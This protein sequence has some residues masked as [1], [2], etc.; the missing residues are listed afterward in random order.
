[1]QSQA[2]VETGLI[3][4]GFRMCKLQ[5]PLYQMHFSHDALF[6][7]PRLCLPLL[8][9]S[10]DLEALDDRGVGGL[11][12]FESAYRLDQ[13]DTS[14]N[15]LFMGLIPICFVCDSLGYPRV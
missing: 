7:L 10:H 6:L 2:A 4:E 3:S 8:Q 11:Q 5:L 9:G 15:P 1:M 14:K 13:L 12:R